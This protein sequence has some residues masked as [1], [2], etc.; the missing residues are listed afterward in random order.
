MQK[1]GLVALEDDCLG[2]V[3]TRSY[4]VLMDSM[5]DRGILEMMIYLKIK[6]NDFT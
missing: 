1:C 4:P 5:S 6:A 3:R 2:L